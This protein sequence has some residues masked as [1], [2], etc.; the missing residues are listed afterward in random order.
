MKPRISMITLGVEDLQRSIEFYE[1]GLGFP[2]LDFESPAVAFFTLNGSWLGLYSRTALAEEAGVPAGH[3]DGF[4]G[5][6]LAHNVESEQAV[7]QTLAVAVAAGAVLSKPAG[8][9]HWGGYSGYFRDP[10]DYLWE[11]AYNP[12]MWVGPEDG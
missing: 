9:M 10:D 1:H 8:K 5:V 12:F 3:G 2:R 7:D 11:V 6:S 4:S